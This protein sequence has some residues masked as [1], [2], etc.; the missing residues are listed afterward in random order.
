MKSTSVSMTPTTL[1]ASKAFARCASHVLGSWR[2]PMH[3]AQMSNA[4]QLAM[5]KAKSV[6]VK[7]ATANAPCISFLAIDQA[8]PK[9]MLASVPSRPIPKSFSSS[10]PVMTSMPQPTLLPLIGQG[11]S[12]SFFFFG[13]L[14][15]RTGC[16]AHSSGCMKNCMSRFGPMGGTVSA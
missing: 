3:F 6:K 4:L 15:R 13:M 10:T 5:A 2:Q 8:S 7:P 11:S 1:E 12:L 9:T 16:D 14:G